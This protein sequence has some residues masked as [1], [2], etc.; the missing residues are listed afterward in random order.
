MLRKLL[1]FRFTLLARLLLP[2]LA[3]AVLVPAACSSDPTRPAEEEEEE[4]QEETSYVVGQT[5]YGANNF[6]EYAVGDLPIV[7]SAPHGGYA[8]PSAIPDRT[9]GTFAHDRN[10]QELART[11]SDKVYAATGSRPHIIIS[12]LHRTK[13]DPNRDKAE[14]AQGNA[15]AMQAWEDWHAFI[16][17]AKDTV[18]AYY[19]SGLYLDLH[20]HGHTFQRI[21]LGYLLSRSTLELTDQQLIAGN[22]AAFSSISALAGMTSADFPELLRGDTSLGGLLMAL[23]VPAVPSPTYPDPGGLDYFSGGPNTRT[24][25]SRYGGMISGIQIE[26][27]WEGIRDTAANRDAYAES[28]ASAVLTYLSTHFGITIPGPAV[29]LAVS[30]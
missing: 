6:I 21:E 14:A 4:Q 12:L 10:T 9:Y 22:H 24:H 19:G 30:P 13:L 3:M 1:A 28:L 16:R 2:L 27:N 7:L 17:A 18:T 11:F 25:G 5:Y 15:L 23:G 20:G 29:A 26:C 8:K